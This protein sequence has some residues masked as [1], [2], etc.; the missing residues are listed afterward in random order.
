[1]SLQ[2]FPDVPAWLRKPSQ[3]FLTP[4]EIEQLD[5]IF[6]RILPEDPARQIPGAVAAGASHFVSHL[7]A[8]DDSVYIE[9]KDWRTLYRSALPALNDYCRVTQG[10]NLPEADDAAV[11]AI[12]SG[13]EAGNLSGLSPT[14][15]QQ[16]VFKTFLRHCVQGC[17]ADPRWGGNKDKMM[18]RAIGYLQQPENLFHD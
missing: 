12:L 17:F 3:E 15:K 6:R 13:L 5:A 9:I 14:I 8:M 10:K 4:Q 18:W 11:N 1:M 16:V 7:L 2:T